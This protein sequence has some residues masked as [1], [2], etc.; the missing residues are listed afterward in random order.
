MQFKWSSKLQFLLR[1]RHNASSWRTPFGQWGS[2]IHSQYV[3]TN[4][5]YKYHVS[6]KCIVLLSKTQYLPLSLW[7]KGLGHED[8]VIK[9]DDTPLDMFIMLY[10]L[11]IRHWTCWL[12]YP[13]WRN[14][15]GHL[16]YALQ[17]GDKSLDMIM[18]SNLTIRHWTLAASASVLQRLKFLSCKWLLLFNW[19]CVQ[20]CCLIYQRY[21][22][23]SATLFRAIKWGS[24]T[25][26]LTHNWILIVPPWLTA[27]CPGK[28]TNY[29]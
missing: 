6:A 8:Y 18:L 10:N 7:M 29:N 27:W 21:V 15:N 23:L 22:A 12:C 3:E 11:T 1:S 16:D 25:W 24:E 2:G 17:F 19:Y 14:A 9:F 13:I 28:D 4:K 5:T 20:W 26:V